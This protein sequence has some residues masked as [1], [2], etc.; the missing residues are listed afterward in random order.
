MCTHKQL[1]H[2]FM[3]IL[4]TSN[5]QC[6]ADKKKLITMRCREWKKMLVQTAE[7]NEIEFY[8]IFF[9]SPFCRNVHI[10]FSFYQ[11]VNEKK[12]NQKMKNFAQITKEIQTFITRQQ[13]C[14]HCAFG[15][16]ENYYSV[17]WKF[18]NFSRKAKFPI[19]RKIGEHIFGTNE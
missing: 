18:R 11:F 8:C 2:V 12:I 10:F 15:W 16:L 4:E 1:R 6:S 19:E 13:Y 9:V 3:A 5:I 7:N 17:R 14:T